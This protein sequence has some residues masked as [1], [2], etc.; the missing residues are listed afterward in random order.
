MKTIII[1]LLKTIRI[2]TKITAEKVVRIKKN[3]FPEHIGDPFIR[4][5]LYRL[6]GIREYQTT[7]RPS[8]KCI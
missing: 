2:I 5:Y 4:I 1:Y 6:N 8:V 7:G 3:R